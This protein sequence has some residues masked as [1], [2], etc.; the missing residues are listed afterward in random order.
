MKHFVF[1]L[2]G[3]LIDSHPPYLETLELVFSRY[4]DES[5]TVDYSLVRKVFAYKFMSLHIPEE[6]MDEA[7][8]YYMQ[9]SLNQVGQIKPF[10]G[11]IEILD[12]L[13][14]RNIPIAIWTGR[15]KKT[16][17][18][19]IENT[20]LDLYAKQIVT[21]DCVSRNKPDPEGL[22]KILERNEWSADD[23]VM[24][25]DSDFDVLGARAAKV[26]AVS[27]GWGNPESDA[28]K[29]QSDR[30]FHAVVDFRRW[31]EA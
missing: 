1:D 28:L 29:G 12:L 20:G 10:D 15:E 16:A 2:D 8:A 18:Q 25:G 14:T 17:I 7:F 22:L 30:H 31:L 13:K 11:V 23:T 3:T 21:G 5:K 19:V 4:K 6:R 27:V 24:V 9:L 26:K